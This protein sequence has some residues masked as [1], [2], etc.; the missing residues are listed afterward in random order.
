VDRIEV[1]GG[2]QGTLFGSA[3]L[4]GAVRLI[5]NKPNLKKFDGRVSL[6]GGWTDN[7]QK[8]NRD[9][10]AM[11]NIPLISDRLAVPIAAYDSYSAGFLDNTPLAQ[12]LAINTT[13]VNNPARFA[14]TQFGSINN[15]NF[16][17]K[18]MNDVEYK[19]ARATAALRI[20][21]D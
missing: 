1:L 18:G 14:N 2:P 21:D 19:G 17:A 6:S 16:Q 12:T 10:E 11:L 4:A 7:A 20:T 8:P 9:L 3:S 15:F 5:T 13:V